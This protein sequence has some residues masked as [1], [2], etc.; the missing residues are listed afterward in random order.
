MWT[1]IVILGYFSFERGA[2]FTKAVGTQFTKAPIHKSPNSQRP[3]SQRHP[4]HKCTLFPKARHPWS[5]YLINNEGAIICNCLNVRV[6][7]NFIYSSSMWASV[8]RWHCPILQRRPET[9]IL[10]NIIEDNIVLL[11]WKVFISVKIS[12][13]SYMHENAQVGLDMFRLFW[14]C[15]VPF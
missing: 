14:N 13:V 2:Q 15:S 10:I 1:V 7:Y 12:I 11:I 8:Q 6:T 4:V 9:I 3:I 5:L